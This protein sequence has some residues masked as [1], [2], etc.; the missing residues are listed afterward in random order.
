[1]TDYTALAAELAPLVARAPRLDPHETPRGASEAELLAFER[2]VGLRLTPDLRVWLALVNGASLRPNGVVGVDPAAPWGSVEG[3]WDAVPEWR[4]NGWVPVASDGG[5][6]YYLALPRDDGVASWVGV[7]VPVDLDR[8][9]YV[10]A[11]DVLRF[12]RFLVEDELADGE[13]PWPFERDYVLARDPGLAA[14]PAHLL[15]WD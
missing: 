5:G 2:R 7:A 3:L 12:V 11:S 6:A 14:A 13:S 15:P 10:V 8:I 4:A 9:A 1:M